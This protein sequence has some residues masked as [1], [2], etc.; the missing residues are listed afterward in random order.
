MAKN[1]MTFS[2][3]ISVWRRVRA[4]REVSPLGLQNKAEAS[5]VGT[6]WAID[7]KSPQEK[8]SVVHTI[9]LLA[10]TAPPSQPS[11]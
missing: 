3:S 1:A 10:A 8:F 6:L 5:M 7:V 4:I 2:L 11:P 9:R